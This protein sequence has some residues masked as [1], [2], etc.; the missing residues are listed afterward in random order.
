MADLTVAQACSSKGRC[1]TPERLC[2]HDAHDVHT[3]QQAQPMPRM[4]AEKAQGRPLVL[5]LEVFHNSSL[6][7]NNTM[8]VRRK[9][10]R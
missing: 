5:Q 9:V 2:A 10:A 3:L 4:A 7:T 6:P 1:Y 8:S